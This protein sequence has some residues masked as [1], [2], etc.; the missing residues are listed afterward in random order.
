MA[1]WLRRAFQNRFT[2]RVYP[3]TLEPRL[4]DVWRRKRIKLHP[5]YENL[6]ADWAY[7]EIDE[8]ALAIN[9]SGH[10]EETQELF[11]IS[12]L[13]IRMWAR[14]VGVFLEALRG[15]RELLATGRPYYE[16]PGTEVCLCLTTL[17]R[18]R[19]VEQLTRRLPHARR[20]ASAEA[21][22]F[23]ALRAEGKS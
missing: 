19:L 20:V 23:A 7:R 6:P 12:G 15:A 3:L 10:I 2:P 17:Q 14:E 5:G 16:L 4:F 22:I 21:S 11:D 8:V 1:L 18:E 13:E 9:T